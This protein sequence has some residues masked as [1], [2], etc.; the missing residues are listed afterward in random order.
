[1]LV[2]DERLQRYVDVVA[3]LTKVVQEQQKTVQDQRATIE[4]LPRR[5]SVV[6]KG[7]RLA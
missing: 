6:E 5:L 3:V 4:E 1:M 2:Q 7:G